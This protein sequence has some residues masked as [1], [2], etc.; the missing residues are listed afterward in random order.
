MCYYIL[1]MLLD[2]TIQWG[3]IGRRANAWNVLLAF[4]PNEVWKLLTLGTNTELDLR[5]KTQ[6]KKNLSKYK[7]TNSDEL[8]NIL[9][10]RMH[11]V[12]SKAAGV[13]HAYEKV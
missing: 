4:L 13:D 9:R 3:S 1:I 7:L 10:A 2:A 5:F 12:Y 8:K 6:R 11:M